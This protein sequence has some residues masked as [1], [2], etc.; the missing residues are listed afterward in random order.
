MVTPLE[1]IRFTIAAFNTASAG[2]TWDTPATMGILESLAEF[3]DSTIAPANQDADTKGCVLS[4][5]RVQMPAPLVS[6]YQEY[7]ALG[8]HLLS[9]PEAHGGIGAAPLTGLAAI[10][11]LAGASHAFQMVVSLVGGASEAIEA[12]GNAEQ[13]QRLIADLASGETLATMCLTE[14]GAGSDL[15]AIKM[16]AVD[17]GDGYWSLSGGKIFISGGDQNLTPRILHLVLARTGPAESRTKGLSL[18]ACPSHLDDGS[19]NAVETIR[20]EEKLGLHGSPT[21]QLSFNAAKAE[22]LG[23]PGEGLK[24]MFVMMNR[25]R[26]EVSLQGVALSAQATQLARTYAETRHQSGKTIDQHPDVKRMLMEMDATTLGARAMVYRTTA[27]LGDSD[28]LTD[29]LTPVCKVFCSDA[30]S[31]V[32]DTGIQ[33]LGGYGYLPEYGIEQLWRDGRVTR[34]YE[35]TNGV[36]AMTLATRLLKL[37]D[38]NLVERFAAEIADAANLADEPMAKCLNEL[39]QLWQQTATTL[40]ESDQPGYGAMPFMQLT[41]LVFFLSAWA[42]LHATRANAAAPERIEQLY[43]FVQADMVPNAAALARRTAQLLQ[44]SW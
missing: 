8:W 36:L 23:A 14:P 39:V 34:L 21:C 3:T 29:F 35:G 2:E 31:H 37:D 18:F 38:G 41:G 43:R 11:V 20:I 10:E 16:K 12:C 17:N 19:R 25:A 9:L 13:Q 28:A 4:D 32:A 5:G 15:G 7:V 27:L 33:V 26:L 22:M 6:A 40:K 1:D 44:Q 30:G 24:A 42:R